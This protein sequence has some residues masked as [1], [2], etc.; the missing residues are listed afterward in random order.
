M[1]SPTEFGRRGVAARPA[2]PSYGAAPPKPPAV[3][4]E[5]GSS[6]GPSP[7]APMLRFFFSFEGRIRRRDYWLG[8][9]GVAAVIYLMIG[10]ESLISPNPREDQLLVVLLLLGVV[11]VL[12]A[13]VWSSLAL[14][15]KRWHDRD[16][17]WVWI[18]IGFIPFI[19]G[20]WELIELGFL[21]G[22]S[23]DNRFGRSP[24]WSADLEF[25]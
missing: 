20:L 2:A 16:K 9:F 15:V 1:S 17:S 19:G 7:I 8:E 22:S 6:T 18:F 21:D 14:R 25:A 10:L 12:I 23:V 5:R 11:V 3:K 13:G 24:K 4:R